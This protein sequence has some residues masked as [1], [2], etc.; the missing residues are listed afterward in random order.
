MANSN[1]IVSREFVKGIKGL[2]DEQRRMGRGRRGR[3]GP[4]TSTFSRG[5]GAHLRGN[6]IEGAELELRPVDQR[7]M[8]F[9]LW[10]V[11]RRM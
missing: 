10:E 7:A 6:M 8:L 4:T 3:V 11:V 5:T 2:H 9:H 1:E